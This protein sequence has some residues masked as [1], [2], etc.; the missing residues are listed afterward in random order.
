MERAARQVDPRAARVS[1]GV[2]ALER[3]Q[4]HHGPAD[5]QAGASRS[6]TSTTCTTCTTCTRPD[7]APTAPGPGP[8]ADPVCSGAPGGHGDCDGRPDWPHRRHPPAT[9]AGERPAYGEPVAR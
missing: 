7:A 6:R 5:G 3:G 1:A 2:L 9:R 8:T 4:S